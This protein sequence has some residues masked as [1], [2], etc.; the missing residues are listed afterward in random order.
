VPRLLVDSGPLFALANK[1]DHRHADAVAFFQ[2]MDGSLVTTL[3]VL[4]EMCSMLPQHRVPIAL[5][6]I[7]RSNFALIHLPESELGAVAALIEKYADRPM[8]LADASLLWA[9]DA[10]AVSEIATLD[11]A[12]HVY[13]TRRGKALR[14]R[15]P[16][17]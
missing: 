4:T 11:S 17:A 9:A 3:A 15:F 8:D 1:R 6:A 2:G 16:A 13:R 5:R 7:E 12:F 14:N 10:L